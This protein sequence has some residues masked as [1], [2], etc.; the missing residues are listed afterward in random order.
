[1]QGWGSCNPATHGYGSW[2]PLRVRVGGIIFRAVQHLD[3]AAAL[4]RAGYCLGV[5]AGGE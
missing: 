4:M 3:A 2:F 5:N 1:M